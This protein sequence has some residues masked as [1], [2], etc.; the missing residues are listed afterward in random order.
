MHVEHSSGTA[1]NGAAEI[2]ESLIVS[3]KAGTD[4]SGVNNVASI[5][6]HV[7]DGATS[8]GF[9]NYVRSANNQ[10]YFTFLKEQLLLRMK[11]NVSDR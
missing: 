6:L 9:I 10:G 8:Q 3:N 4:D 11:N 7:A 1:Y 2:T 5:G